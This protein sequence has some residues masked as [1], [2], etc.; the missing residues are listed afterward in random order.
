[1][2]RSPRRTH[3]KE[4][5]EPD[6]KGNGVIT[7]PLL[8]NCDNTGEPL[9]G[10]PRRGG[11]GSNTVTDH[12]TV[13]EDSIAALPSAC[14]RRLM[15]TSD[16]A[17]A[18]H[19]LT[20]R[21]DQLASWRQLTYSLGWTWAPASARRAGHARRAAGA[22]GIHVGGPLAAARPRASQGLQPP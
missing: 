18:S 3:C 8:A 12:L 6:F 19:G 14:R 7:H 5:A 20:A 16:G 4:L 10:M 13:L 2:P 11:A 21:L 17:G 15:V 1:M 22:A 9:A